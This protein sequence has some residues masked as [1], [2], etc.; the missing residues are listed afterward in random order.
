MTIHWAHTN[1]ENAADALAAVEQALAA[2]SAAPS[3][4]GAVDPQLMAL[5]RDDPYLAEN[6][7]AL[8]A[9][10][11]VDPHAIV[12]S[13]RPGLAWA[14]NR[15]QQLVR[16]ATWWYALPQWL[17]ISAFHGAVVRTMASLLK[18]QR[19]LEQR[20]DDVAG[21]HVLVRTALLEQEI[22][23][24]RAELAHLRERLAQLEDRG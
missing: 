9:G 15:F 6:L 5:V 24:L 8:H 11:A 21:G 12:V 1:S 3:E 23:A 20:M 7:R 4:P 19:R 2:P 13:S 14:I 22:L 18:E 16:R 17:Q 10:W